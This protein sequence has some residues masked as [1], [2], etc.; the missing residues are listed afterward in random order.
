[1]I[2]KPKQGRTPSSL[3]ER[4]TFY[5]SKFHLK[6]EKKFPKL[7]GK[8]TQKEWREVS[9]AFWDKAG[10]ILVNQPN[11]IVL[12]GLGYF[13]FPVY[14]KKVRSPFTGK[15]TFKQNGEVPYPQFFGS[16]YKHFYL[17]GLSFDL[18]RKHKK[19]WYKRLEEGMKYKHHYHIIKD[20][21]GNGSKHLHST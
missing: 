17:G 11:G 10:E 20:I 2:D 21:L 12:D 18:S 8:Y 1:M 16:I 3:G 4:K 14:S 9:R 13:S 6:I 15:T 7:K 5:E 19:E